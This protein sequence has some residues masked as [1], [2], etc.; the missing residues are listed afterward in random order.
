MANWLNGRTWT[1]RLHKVLQV[2]NGKI[3]RKGKKMIK[4]FAKISTFIVSSGLSLLLVFPE[5]HSAD[6]PKKTVKIIVCADVGGGE[7]TEARGLAPYLQRHL[8]VNIIIENQVGAGDSR[9]RE[10]RAVWRNLGRRAQEQHRHG[11][12]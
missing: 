12:S 6:F 5:A 11:N 1:R 9:G 7:D 3:R 4:T 2:V 8:G 10:R